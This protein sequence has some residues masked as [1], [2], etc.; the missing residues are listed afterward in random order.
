[1]THQQKS[2]SSFQ[3]VGL[4]FGN[5]HAH[6]IICSFLLT[7]EGEEYTSDSTVSPSSPPR[8]RMAHTPQGMFSYIIVGDDVDKTVKPRYMMV[9]HQSQSLH[10][11]HAYAALDRVDFQHLPNS[12]PIAQV[13]S[14]PNSSF[15]PNLED[16]A[17][18]RSNYAVILGHELVRLVPFL[19]Q[20]AE[21]VPA[22]ITR[23]HSEEMSRSVIVS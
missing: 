5:V 4:I 18:L 7:T 17:A 20:F 10:Y 22:H 3:Q 6:V 23:Q 19:K 13:S 14:L 8:P 9:D 15:L 1:M 2:H 11:F 21:Y 16:C 12:E